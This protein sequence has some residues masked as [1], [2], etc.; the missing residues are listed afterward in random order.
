ML[1]VVTITESNATPTKDHIFINDIVGKY[2][3]R[4]IY[5]LLIFSTERQ[6]KPR[7]SSYE[8]DILPF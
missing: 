7:Q 6:L 5:I 1:W 3:R 4:F 2:F 8:I